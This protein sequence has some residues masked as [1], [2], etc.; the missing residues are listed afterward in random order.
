MLTIQS[1]HSDE[2]GRRAERFRKSLLFFAFRLF[3]VFFFQKSPA[4][5]KVFFI[6]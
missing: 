6:A 3:S 2:Y 4:M 5:H 1:L